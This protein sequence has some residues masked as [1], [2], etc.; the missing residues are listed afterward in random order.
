[1]GHGN[2]VLDG[3]PAV[4]RDV[5]MAT[6]FWLSTGYNFVCIIASDTLFYSRG[7]FSGSNYPMKTWPRL[8]NGRCHG[9]H[10]GILY[11]GCTLAPPGEYD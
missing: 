10:F 8:S 9:N 2:R 6:D 5:P 1:M 4:M 3:G 11:M 7:V